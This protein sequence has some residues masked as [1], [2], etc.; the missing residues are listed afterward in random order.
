MATRT[1]P[2]WDLPLSEINRRADEL[3]RVD[4]YFKAAQQQVR[5]DAAASSRV[6]HEIFHEIAKNM[7]PDQVFAYSAALRRGENPNVR[8]YTDAR[9]DT[10]GR[11]QLIT[12]T[13]EDVSGR[14]YYEYSFREPGVGSKTATWMKP[15]LKQPMLQIRVNRRAGQP[16]S[17]SDAA[18]LAQWEADQAMRRSGVFPPLE[19]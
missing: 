1:R 19:L 18:F 5:A 10:A 17:V 6:E 13:R 7:T 16:D 12:H 11:E 3:A 4:R 2:A 14:K 15:F 9:A 8:D